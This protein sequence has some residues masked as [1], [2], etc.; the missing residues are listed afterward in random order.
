MGRKI[1]V[2]ETVNKDFNLP[3]SF[4]APVNVAPMTFA[5]PAIP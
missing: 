1:E 3:S 4:C 5:M 2:K